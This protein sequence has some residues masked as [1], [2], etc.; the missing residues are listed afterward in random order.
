MMRGYVRASAVLPI[1]LL[2]AAAATSTQPVQGLGDKVVAF[3]RAHRGEIV[4][5][6]EC[7]VLAQKALKDAG[8]KG[9]LPDNPEKGD[10]VWGEL[11]LAVEPSDGGVKFENGKARNLKPGDI[12]QYRDAHFAGGNRKRHYVMT[13]GHHTAVVNA[14]ADF[15]MTIHV[16]QQNVGGDKTVREGVIHLEDLKTGWLRFYRPIARGNE[17]EAGLG[18]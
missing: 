2:C 15:G 14:V 4:G 12:I 6:G 11:V 9:R 7:A 10:Y 3:C 17:Q 8:A 1:L 16:L 13:A 18:S 5:N